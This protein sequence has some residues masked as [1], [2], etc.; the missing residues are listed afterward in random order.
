MYNLINTLRSPSLTYPL[1][2]PILV[3]GELSPSP[4]LI[5]NGLHKLPG[6]L[7]SRSPINIL[8]NVLK[9]LVSLHRLRADGILLLK[10]DEDLPTSNSKRTLPLVVIIEALDEGPIT[11][12]KI[13]LGEDGF[14]SVS[15]GLS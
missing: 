10:V 14:E 12:S 13:I 3:L 8:L 7:V 9:M 11:G 4:H 5:D 2:L 6:P 15:V 1:Q